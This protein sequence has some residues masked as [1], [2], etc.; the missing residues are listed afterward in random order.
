M[1][2]VIIDTNVFLDALLPDGERPQGDRRSAQLILDAVSQRTVAGLLSSV[3]F[4]ELVHVG[5]PRRADRA[6]VAT[7]LEYLLDICEW[8]PITAKTYRTAMVSSFADVNDAAIFFAASRP[9]AIVTR[10]SDFHDH[11]NV[12]VYTAAQFVAKHLK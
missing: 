2:R 8:T 6:Q 12:P 7:A 10:D 3:V 11:V 9:D 1:I 4:S 5:K